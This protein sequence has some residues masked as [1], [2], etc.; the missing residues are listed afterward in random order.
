[1]W[2]FFP[3]IAFIQHQQANAFIK[4]HQGM[5]LT[6]P[7]LITGYS[8]FSFTC[9]VIGD[10]WPYLLLLTAFLPLFFLDVSNFWL[11][12]GFTNTFWIAGIV[13]TFLPGALTTTIMAIVSSGG[14]FVVLALLQG[15]LSK[16]LNEEPLGRGDIHLMAALC[17]WLP[18]QQ[19][20][21][22][23]GVALLGAACVMVK[24]R[25]QPLAPYLFAA[26]CMFC[27]L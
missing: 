20:W 5:S 22:I 2:L 3:F 17:A 16:R 8:L 12:L 4:E 15:Y 9:Y 19:A 18:L 27:L 26:V 7:M 21:T 23:L 6:L 11:P 10:N 24:H 1:M 13:T 14:V 25:P